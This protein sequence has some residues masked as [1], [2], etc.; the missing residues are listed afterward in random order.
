MLEPKAEKR[1]KS[2]RLAAEL[3]LL[4]ETCR[5]DSGF[6][7]A[8]RGQAM[9]DALPISDENTSTALDT[10]FTDRVDT[11]CT[12]PT[13]AFH[14]HDQA[15]SKYAEDNISVIS[16]P[17]EALNQGEMD[18]FVRVICETIRFNTPNISNI[19]ETMDSQ[20]SVQH[21]IKAELETFVRAMRTRVTG[22]AG[23]NGLKAMYF[24]RHDIAQLYLDRLLPPIQEVNPRPIISG[25]PEEMSHDEKMTNLFLSQ[26]DGEGSGEEISVVEFP[27]NN[28]SDEDELLDIPSESDSERDDLVIQGINVKE[29]IDRFVADPAF[30]AL[31][32]G[33]Q[34]AVE[35]FSDD[36]LSIIQHRVSSALKRIYH[37][38]P[39]SELLQ[40]RFHISWNLADYLQENYDGDP[41]DLSNINATTGV[42]AK[43]QLCTV[44]EYFQQVEAWKPHCT[45]LIQALRE[46]LDKRHSNSSA[47]QTV[48]TL[49]GRCR[50]PTFFAYIRC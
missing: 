45:E 9:F 23:K 21:Q 16:A 29:V 46:A 48:S 34:D 39:D 50:V 44:G 17:L 10:I 18:D 36:K 5:R 3:R 35:Q 49:T 31:V 19:I 6:Y 15:Q 30:K 38:V 7:E 47:P 27:V 43:A 25:L 41:P 11:A 1:I 14:T 37:P 26:P 20:P 13:S 22:K 24:L 40:A 32:L 28:P 8:K 12:A 2:N 33:I 42:L 4:A